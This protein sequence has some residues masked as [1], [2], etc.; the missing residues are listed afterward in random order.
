MNLSSQEKKWLSRLAKIFGGILIIW[1]LYLAANGV[2]NYR[3]EKF[4]KEKKALI[5]RYQS[6]IDS[7]NRENKLLFVE[8]NKLDKEIDSL[9]KVKVQ[10]N[11]EY[12]EEVNIVYDA[13]AADHAE[14][15]DSIII[16]LKT[17]K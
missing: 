13:T 7:L 15:L 9:Q 3:T 4:I 17:N 5:E 16:K 10:I 8:I 6:K 14:W 11:E 2:Y 12:N 1:L